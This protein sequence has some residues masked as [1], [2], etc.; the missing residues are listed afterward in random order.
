MV[1]N[2]KQ[3]RLVEYQRGE[4]LQ[5]PQM[6]VSVANRIISMA[7]I[8]D[9]LANKHFLSPPLLNCSSGVFTYQLLNIINTKYLVSIYFN[10]F[11]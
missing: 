9:R 7:S 8:M 11:D 2:R 3:I 1:G 5:C 6:S 10:L 4:S